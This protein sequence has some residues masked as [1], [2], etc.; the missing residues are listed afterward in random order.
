MNPKIDFII[1]ELIK[2]YPDAH[3]S[4]NHRNAFELLI[5]V[6]LSAQTTD[7]RVNQVTPTLFAR[8]PDA[9]AMS[10][11]NVDEV[12]KIIH[13]IGLYRNK[14]RNIVILS[15]DIQ[16]RFKGEVPSKRHELMS[17]P[18]VGKKTAN[19]VLADAF[20]IPAMAVDTHVSRI[21]KRLGLAK[22]DDD[23][24]NIEANLCRK[25]PR[26]LWIRMHHTMIYFGRYMCHSLNPN[27]NECPFK[28]LCKRQKYEKK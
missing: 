14:S 13:S 27:C 9:L 28:H 6:V 24:L 4:L 10:L 26:H 1:N 12:A 25:I 11:A 18:G 15:K 3:C 7:E 21:A 23:V 16:E 17:L 22:Y 5:A 2:L 19:V 8:Y 20:N